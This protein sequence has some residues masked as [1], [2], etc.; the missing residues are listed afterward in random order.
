MV[1]IKI[2][3]ATLIAMCLSTANSFEVHSAPRVRLGS[4]KAAYVPDGLTAAEYQKIKAEDKKK[5]G[6][7]L[8]KLGARGFQSR[9]LQGWQEAFDRGEVVHYIAPVGYQKKLSKGEMKKEEVPVSKPKW[10]AWVK[11]SCTIVLSQQ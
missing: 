4:L 1:S 9:S 7:N 10:I 11:R 3:A 6:K 8:G 2:T 5:L